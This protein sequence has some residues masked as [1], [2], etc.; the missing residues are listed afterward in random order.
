[1]GSEKNFDKDSDNSRIIA[2]TILSR[3]GRDVCVFSLN[4]ALFYRL[5]K[6]ML[7]L[8]SFLISGSY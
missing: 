4:A 1:M 5:Y 3:D 2:T 6:D 8:I 7:I